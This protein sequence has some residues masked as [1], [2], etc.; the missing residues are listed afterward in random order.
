M[1]DIKVKLEKLLADA[2]A[3]VE[4]AAATIETAVRERLVEA[5][6]A[7][8]AALIAN[9][10]AGEEKNRGQGAKGAEAQEPAAP[11]A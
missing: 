11:A 5:T 7:I 6:N 1:D 4:E 9:E 10:R 2:K 8:E 3:L